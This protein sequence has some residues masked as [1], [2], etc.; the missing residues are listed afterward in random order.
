MRLLSP[1]TSSSFG[2]SPPQATPKSPNRENPAAITKFAVCRLA[3]A[4]ATM[5][6]ILDPSGAR[7]A[8]CGKS[9]K[10]NL[11]Y[12][13]LLGRYWLNPSDPDFDRKAARICNL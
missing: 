9:E 10:R 6:L 11:I 7:R 12:R 8:S 4:D 1:L 3:A 5:V 13:T 2:S